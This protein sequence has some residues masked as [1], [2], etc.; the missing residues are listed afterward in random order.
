MEDRRRGRPCHRREPPALR[1]QASKWIGPT[2]GACH[3]IEGGCD[4]LKCVRLDTGRIARAIHARQATAGL[5]RAYPDAGDAARDGHARQVSA[6]VKRVTLDVGDAA[7]DRHARQARAIVERGIPDAG[8]AGLDG[9]ARQA[10]A[11]PERGSPDARDATRDRH[12]RQARAIVERPVPDA[13]DAVR[14][15]HASQANAA[16]ERRIPDA[17]DA[18]RNRHAR[19]VGAVLKSVVPDAGDGV[20]F[21]RGREG[22]VAAHTGVAGDRD[23]AVSNG[24]GHAVRTRHREGVGRSRGAVFGGDPI[25]RCSCTD[26]LEN[27]NSKFKC[28][29]PNFFSKLL[30]DKIF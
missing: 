10:T 14:D 26:I 22:Q 27:C 29:T 18:A 13:A 1:R 17:G 20:A 6:G 12:A 2:R 4:T 11:F 8:D 30:I 19:Q 15:G 9:H 21:D 23:F 25:D 7:R 28:V 16:V 24:V 5:E 3:I